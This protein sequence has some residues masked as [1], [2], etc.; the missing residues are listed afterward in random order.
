MFL[1]MRQ[2]VAA[3]VTYGPFTINAALRDGL[4]PFRM[5]A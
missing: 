3:D 1:D 4:A 2:T 5:A